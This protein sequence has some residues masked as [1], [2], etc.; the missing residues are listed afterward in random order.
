MKALEQLITEFPPIVQSRG[1]DILREYL[2][3]EI[4]R[5]LFHSKYG[6]KFTFLGGTCI[7]IV[8]GNERFSEDLDFDNEGLTV[9][10]FEATAATIQREL[11]LLGYTATV[12]FNYK[13]A[14]HYALKFPGLQYQYGLSGHKEARLLLKIDTEKQEYDYRA[15]IVRLVKFGVDTEIRTV[16]IE[17]L[18]SQK[19]T[20]AIGRKRPKGR[21]FYDLIF[22][23]ARAKP[24]YGYLTNRL[25][26]TN[27][28]ELRAYV[29]ERI[30]AFDFEALGRDVQAFL[31]VRADVRRVR[32]FPAFW[33][34]VPL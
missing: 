7:R 27:A 2:Q 6:Y 5:I 17:L 32:D 19:I 29:A 24:D 1:E 8:H 25:G 9:E 10:E 26:V 18:L 16:P 12:K 33:R 11:G 28:Q 3:Y 34:A 14:Y 20:A 30:A 21:D 4:L 23:L 15:N 31:F 22:L 13:G